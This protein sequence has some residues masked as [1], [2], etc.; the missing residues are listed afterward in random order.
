M[1]LKEIHL[2]AFK[3]FTD[4]H[5]QGLPATA[6]LIVLAGPNG[7]GKSSLFDGLKT[8]HWVNGAVGHA[9]DESYGS[10]I[11]APSIP[12]HE[13]VRVELHEPIPPGPEDRKKL[14]YVRSAFRHEAEFN[15]TSLNRIA[16]PLDSPRVQRMIDNDQSVSDNYQ[17]LI[18]ATIS[19]V[20]DSEIPDETPKGEVR[21]RIIGKVQEAMSKVFP[22]LLLEGVGPVL[23]DSGSTGT[24]Y[25][26]KG[27][28]SKFLYKNLSAG[29]KAAFD[30]ILDAVVKGRYFDNSVWCIDEPEGH[31]NTRVQATL[32]RTLMELVPPNSQVILASHSI[33]F[34]REAWEIAQRDPESVVFLDLQGKDFDQPAI[35]TPTIP[36]RAFWS[37]ALDVALGDL[38]QLVAPDEIV[39]CEGRPKV[40]NQDQKAEFDASCYRV[41]FAGEKPNTDFLSIGNSDDVRNDRLGAGQAIQAVNAGTRVIKLIDRDLMNEEEVDHAKENGVRVLSRRHIESFLLDDEVL[42]ALCDSVQ[43][44]ANGPDLIAAKDAALQASIA[45][46]ND[47]DDLKSIAGEVF[48]KARTLLSLSQPGSGW[49]AFAKGKLAPL[50]RPGMR[51]YADLRADIFD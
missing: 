40:K 15:M 30:L 11:G 6:R 31:L 28:A 51:A 33:G 3:R 12:W 26:S 9:W 8:W 41:I 32:M 21:D 17:R 10:K 43:Q 19:G 49:E 50:L 44:D 29:E 36:S 7:S 38:A 22:D 18:M 47:P 24:F 25:F 48:N 37:R 5:I 14:V 16:S 46:G 42:Q 45:R 4:T 13:H 34:M 20:F 23:A 1:R 35:V 2:R 27:T 39:L